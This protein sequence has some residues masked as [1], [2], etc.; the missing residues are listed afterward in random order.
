MWGDHIHI[1]YLQNIT[2]NN[3]LSN[4]LVKTILKIWKFI[5]YGH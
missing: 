2:R 4:L 3:P 5:E 1:K